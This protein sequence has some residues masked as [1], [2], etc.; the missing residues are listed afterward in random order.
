[1]P[2]PIRPARW[3]TIGFL[4]DCGALRTPPGF[5]RPV[6]AMPAGPLCRSGSGGWTQCGSSWL[7]AYSLAGKKISA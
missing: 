5:P 1:A 7:A 2:A 4:V 6:P 3:H